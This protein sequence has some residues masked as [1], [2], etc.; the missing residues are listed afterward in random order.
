MRWFLVS[1]IFVV[2]LFLP[3]LSSADVTVFVPPVVTPLAKGAPAPFAGILLTPE[4]VANVIATANECPKRTQVEVDRARGEEQATCDKKL[5]DAKSDA[6]RDGAVFQAGIDQRDGTIKD[7]L[8]RLDKSEQARGNTWLWVGGGVLAG[9]VIT[10]LSVVV[11][12]VAK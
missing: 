9:V 8:V 6:K 11:V 3:S 10:T 1:L 7:L 2:T 12:N 5:A 4:A